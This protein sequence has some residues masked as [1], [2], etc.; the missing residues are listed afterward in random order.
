MARAEGKVLDLDQIVDLYAMA[1]EV[2]AFM[3]PLAI[4]RGRTIA[5][6]GETAQI[7]VR[8]NSEALWDAL[9]NLI[10]NAVQHAPQNTEVE[11]IVGADATITV[12][13][14]GVGISSADRESIFR[15]FWRGPGDNGPGAGLGLSIVAETVAAHGGTITVS[16]APQGGAEFVIRLPKAPP[17]THGN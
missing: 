6:S 3:A 16:N 15:P 10:E 5:L 11:V 8:G 17:S 14:G 12:R 1:A 13:D 2:V 7:M 9:R 4:K